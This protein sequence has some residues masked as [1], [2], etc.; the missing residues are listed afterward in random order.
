MS[1]DFGVKRELFWRLRCSSLVNSGARACVLLFGW[2]CSEVGYR[3]I[4][5]LRNTY[6]RTTL[7]TR[8]AANAMPLVLDKALPGE[9]GTST[10]ARDRKAWVCARVVCDATLVDWNGE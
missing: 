8:I 7:L 1:N 5:P 3:D 2:L 4:W 6:T 9:L 10:C